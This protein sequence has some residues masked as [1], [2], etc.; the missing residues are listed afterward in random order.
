MDHMMKGR[1]ETLGGPDAA[2]QLAPASE[3]RVGQRGFTLIELLV[4]IAII[5]TKRVSH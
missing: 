2:V 4:V 1:A 3:N 5:A